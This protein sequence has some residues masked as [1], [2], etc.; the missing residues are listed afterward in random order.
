MYKFKSLLR[1]TFLCSTIMLVISCQ[2]EEPLHNKATDPKIEYST[3]SPEELC[4]QALATAML[5]TNGL[6]ETQACILTDIIDNPALTDAQKAMAI[7]QTPSLS[8]YS[9]TIQTSINTLQT[10]NFQTLS[11][12]S[13]SLNLITDEALAQT[14]FD[15]SWINSRP[16]ADPCAGYA[17]G[18]KSCYAGQAVCSLGAVFAGPAAMLVLAACMVQA[19]YCVDAVNQSYP[20][21][22]GLGGGGTSTPI[23]PNIVP[24]D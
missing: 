12:S 21:C 10:Q 6:S 2:K 5:A 24:C 15:P 20:D 1:T 3:T 16:N 8:V 11:Q 22:S 18:L 17:S 13:V 9:A 19:V 23:N 4:G 14:G 7:N